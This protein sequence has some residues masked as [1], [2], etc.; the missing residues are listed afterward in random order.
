MI[1]AKERRF[2]RNF[3]GKKSLYRINELFYETLH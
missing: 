1:R 2:H 3:E